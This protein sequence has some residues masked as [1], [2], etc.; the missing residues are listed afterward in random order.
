MFAFCWWPLRPLGLE[1]FKVRLKWL[2][3]RDAVK[4]RFFFV[5]AVFKTV[6]QPSVLHKVLICSLFLLLEFD[7][8]N[9]FKS[10]LDG[11]TGRFFFFFL[12]R[13]SGS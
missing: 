11:G 4:E 8:P 13:M 6:D 3:S 1:I 5:V 7:L 2:K 12:A 9:F 10:D